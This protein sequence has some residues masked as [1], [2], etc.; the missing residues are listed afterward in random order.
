MSGGIK[1]KIDYGQSKKA[2]AIVEKMTQYG[3]KSVNFAFMRAV[4]RTAAGVKT[5]ISRNIR[6]KYFIK[7]SDIKQSISLKRAFVG[8]NSVAEIKSKGKA[9][10]LYFFQVTPKQRT[11]PRPKIGVAA[12]VK[13]GGSK[14]KIP[15]SFIAH[16]RGRT[17]VYIRKGKERIPIKQLYGPSIPQMIG[18]PQIIEKIEKGAINRLEKNLEHELNRFFKKI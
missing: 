18:N 10:P 15:G 1:I 13:K 9:I 16:S 17:G 8:K 4:N 5:D 2:Q 7:A 14:K 3:N 6:D 12:R 11:K